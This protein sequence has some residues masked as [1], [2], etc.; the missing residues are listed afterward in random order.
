[1][2]KF[3]IKY[4]PTF[5]DKALRAAFSGWTLWQPPFSA[6]AIYQ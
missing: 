6:L 2:E 1:M 4:G 5:L 3:L